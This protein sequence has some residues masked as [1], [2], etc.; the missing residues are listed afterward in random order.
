MNLDSLKKLKTKV[1]DVC[2]R[3][4]KRNFII[5]G[6]VML[7][8]IA[9]A[10]NLVIFNSDKNDGFDYDQSAGMNTD[11]AGNKNPDGD[12]SKPDNSA[13]SYFSS[14]QVNRQRTRDEAIEVLQSVV[15]NAASTEAAKNDALAQISK[16]AGVMEAEA[17]IE[18]LIIAKGFAECV[19][20]ISEDGASIV[21]KSEG[22]NPAQISQINEIVYAQAGIEPVNIKIIER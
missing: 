2:G 11:G 3:I 7:T 22:L 6:A 4:G 20:V 9:V 14:V 16:L 17:N 5:F 13:D 19:A 12:A 8:V 15:E 21:V 10:V 18:T 1:I